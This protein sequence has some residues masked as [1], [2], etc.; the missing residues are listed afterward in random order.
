VDERAGDGF[1]G[2]EPAPAAG[3]D[4]LAYVIYTSG[5]TGRPKGVQVPHRGIANR[6]RWMQDA[7]RLTGADTVL[8]KTPVSF[9]VSVWELFWPL[10]T[11]ARL[12]LAEPGGHRDPEHLAALV[13][14][15]RV[16]VCHFVPP[17]LD[18]F[19][20][21]GRAADCGSLRLVV[22]SG[23]ALPADLAR[24]FHLALPEAALE[25]LYGPTEASVDV[26]RWTSRP[27]WTG[28]AVPIGTPIANTRAY[29]LDALLRPAPVGVPGEL[30]L[31]GVQLARGYGG[32]PGLTADRFV[33]DPYGDAPGARLY[34]TGDLARWH[35]DGYVEYLGRTD[36]QVKVRGFR[37]EL[38]EIEAALLDLEPV[39]QAVAVV[40]EDR[41]GDRRIVAY[42]TAAAREP[43]AGELRA[44]LAE[45]LPDHMVPS[46]FVVLDALPLSPN[47]KVDRKALPV[48]DHGAGTAGAHTA[49]AT[50]QEE[51]LAGLWQ[52]VLGLDRVGTRDNFF[53]IGG[54]SMHAV[55][56]VGLA[57][58]AGHEIPLQRL[59]AAQTVEDLARWL[60]EHTGPA[61]DR[62]G[63]PARQEVAAF[64]LLSPEDLA[65][66]RA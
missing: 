13:R 6:L 60:A 32:R 61:G 59:F 33:P 3:P 47:G 49:P 17:M 36:H 24:R 18:T 12:V 45:R 5:S 19:L 38:G 21:A 34:R 39:A 10:L 53:E 48:P 56:I 41:P 50:P 22:C 23:E 35:A 58:E 52:R 29:V 62:A 51:L 54:D 66:L 7:Y 42:L 26:T 55:R 16:T 2:T 8:Q 64:G 11:G 20:A 57:R 27:G 14:D 28:A 44:A 4:H 37:I 63:G 65:R 46:A 43:S 1:P 30:Y 40:R 15:E 31:G 9:D 25:N